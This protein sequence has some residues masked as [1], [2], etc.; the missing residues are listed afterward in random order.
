[1][2]L[3]SSEIL[4]CISDAV[5][6]LDSQWRF[7]YVNRRAGELSGRSA[8]SMVGTHLWTEFPGI[9][10]QA[11]GDACR[12]AAAERVPVRIEDYSEALGRWFE[13]RIHPAQDGIC[14]F[15]TDVTERRRGEAA[16]Q[17]SEERFRTLVE[18]SPEPIGI[19]VEGRFAY[20]NPAMVRLLGAASA[21]ELLERPVLR[22]VHPDDRSR[23]QERIRRMLS[24]DAVE[25]D[26]Q[27]WVRL[28]GEE[29]WV[30]AVSSPTT[31]R[32]RPAHQTFA[33]DVTE[34]VRADRH[35]RRQEAYFRSLAENSAD[36]IVVL[37]T[38]GTIRYQNPASERILGRS[39]REVIGTDAGSRVHPDDWRAV[40]RRFLRMLRAPEESA[41]MRLRVRDRDGSWRFIEAE[42]RNLVDD[43]AVH[44]V[45]VNARDVTERVR[46]EERLRESEERLSLAL[47]G[48][49]YGMWDWNMLTDEV[50][51]SPGWAAMLGLDPAEVAPAFRSWEERLH[52][53]D[54]DRVI[55]SLRAHVEGTVPAYDSEYRLRHRDGHWVWVLDRGRVVLRDEQGAPI[56]TTGLMSDVSV[57]KR[58]EQ[59][60]AQSEERFRLVTRATSDVIWDYDLVTG[61]VYWGEALAGTFGYDPREERLEIGWWEDRI[62]SDDGPRV[63]G[64]LRDAIDGGQTG[65]SDEYRFRRADGQYAV[66]Y[67]RGSIHRDPQGRP[68]RVI[69]AMQDVTETRAAEAEMR[70]LFSA[71]WDVILVVDRDGT[72]RKIAPASPDL[73][74]L[75]PE[76]LLGRTF[77]E[78][79]PSEQADLFLDS[80]RTA[81]DESR[82]VSVEYP[83]EISGRKLWFSATLSPMNPD[84]VVWIA[85]DVT[86]RRSSEDALRASERRYRE[87]FEQSRDTIYVRRADGVVIDVNPAAEEAFA[88]SREDLLGRNVRELY[89][90][91]GDLERL[92]Q[93]VAIHGSLRNYEVRLRRLNGSEFDALV[94][95]TALHAPDGEITGYQGTVHDITERKN[96]ERR[97]RAQEARF[98]SL[99]ENVHDII[100]VLEPD[101][102]ISYISPSV[103]RALGYPAEKFLGA[104]ASR[105]IHPDDYPAM[106][107][108]V[109]E[110]LAHP[111]AGR[112]MHV[113]ARCRDESWRRLEIVSRNLLQDPDVG[114]MILTARDV[115]ERSAAE[116]ALQRSEAWFRSLTQNAL[117]IT[118]VLDADGRIRYSTP[119]AARTLG[120]DQDH[121]RGRTL[122]DLIHPED[123]Q[124]VSSALARLVGGGTEPVGL[125]ARIRARD[126][127]WQVHQSIAQSLLHDP[128]VGGI[129]INSRDVTEQRRLEAQLRQAQKM[130]A[131]GRLAG[132]VAHDFNNVL[133]AITGFAA[134]L[135]GELPTDG[136]AS[137]YLTEIHKA[138][139]RAASLTR[140]LLAFG[141]KQALRPKVVNL[142]S[143]VA[144]A[145]PML[146][147][148]VREDIELSYRLDS[149]LGQCR[150]DPHQVEQ[151]LVNLV[152][153]A[154][155]ALPEGGLIEISTT[156]R[157][158]TERER[159]IH[160]YLQP[161]RYTGL[162]V[163]D[164]GHGMDPDTVAKIFEPFFTTKELGKG[165]GLGLSTV[166][167][168]VK[169]SG[170]YISVESRRGVGSTFTV[171]FPRIEEEESARGPRVRSPLRE[172]NG[173]ILLA[174]DEDAVRHLARLT[175]QKAGYTVLEARDG[176]EALRI[177]REHTGE[178][179]LLLTDVVMPY[180][181]GYALARRLR[182]QRPTLRVVFMSGYP[183]NALRDMGSQ[184]SEADFVA[185]PIT[186]EA[187]TQRIEEALTSASSGSSTGG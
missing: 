48:S 153:N 79:L 148:L 69:G 145:G 120:Y 130:E 124:Q 2:N 10:G 129:V 11:F 72:Y 12:R 29:I 99:I 64:G 108:A 19:A 88:T 168:I 41:S 115:T 135:E 60:L 43:P 146:R 106:A 110:D 96:A 158:L 3:S 94:S 102:T 86:E 151:V 70:A 160:A 53:E 172:G 63:L 100:T 65:W 98:R 39:D 103:E 61:R 82:H 117:D 178:I 109:N 90:D 77:H 14:V 87:I 152:V 166:Y 141:R 58:A 71:M 30:E 147:R 76:E 186:P 105:W 159:R 132:G 142:N 156:N 165:T 89:V 4:E 78:V 40:R 136:E 81:L 35:L 104:P 126:D 149:L 183:G 59:Q 5:I 111:G 112:T 133:M 74:L 57:R 176:E 187:L 15:F 118:T 27:R 52:P 47:R 137:Q 119:S 97:L 138:A 128:S 55:A 75:P 20:A 56:R 164:T 167:G 91:P 107:A 67:D 95:T 21:A 83:M 25:G 9:V 181:G 50:H 36:L 32:G 38:D 184:A 68:I 73:L 44:G 170:G 116:E 49:G 144:G 92:E 22:S 131:V 23:V 66:G 8:E 171:L 179:D 125:A 162:V 45:V 54:R 93:A 150:V 185:K 127:S 174:E 121:L 139:D 175:L 85:R 34:Q 114:G 46:A 6:A 31:Y 84:T 16:L 140:Q 154:T 1:M 13:S 134:L 51:F 113:R 122:L 161:G 169:Q 182:E 155:D 157:L 18:S 24:G 180:L 7:T 80:V 26:L 177:A 42:G 62:H 163:R 101:G 37:E 17:Q 123:R 28:D 173:T 33:R 143:V